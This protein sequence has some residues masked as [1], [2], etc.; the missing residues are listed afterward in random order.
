MLS[1]RNLLFLAVAVTGSVIKRDAG[2]VKSDLQLINTDTQ[3]VTAAVN[4]YNGGGVTNAL[5]IVRAQSKLSRDIKSAT[6]HAK[7]AGGIS[8]ADAS[9]IIGYIKNTLQP[10]IQGSLSA[11]KTKKGNFDADGL[12]PT[13]KS[14]LESLKSDTDNLSAA[15]IAGT[16][17]SKVSE[18]KGVSDAIDASFNDAI[19]YF[20]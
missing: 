19:A 3:A 7:A 17:P 9:A 2:Q 16:P 8:E 10:S 1:V 20:S 14:S 4:N 12:T 11:L 6:D 5:P 15:L 13:V 18:A